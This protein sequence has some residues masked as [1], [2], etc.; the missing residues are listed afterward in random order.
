[1]GKKWETF[2]MNFVKN[3]IYTKHK[4]LIIN[5]FKKNKTAYNVACAK[6][7]LS[8]ENKKSKTDI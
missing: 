7:A 2:L 8:V 1:V 5:I 4:Y 6:V 3:L